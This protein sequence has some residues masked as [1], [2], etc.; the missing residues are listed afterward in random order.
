MQAA[1]TSYLATPVHPVEQMR[2]V[3][4]SRLAPDFVGFGRQAIA[5]PLTPEK[6]RK[7]L[8]QEIDWC[9]RCFG[10]F[11]SKQCKHY[12]QESPG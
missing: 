6:L 3:L 5:D 7:N 4:H 9:K 1:F 12:G 10:C 11:R 2:H 8:S